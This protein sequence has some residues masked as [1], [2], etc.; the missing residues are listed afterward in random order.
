[1][2]FV[3]ETIIANHKDEI[4]QAAA[5]ELADSMR[6]SKPV[7]ERFCDILEEELK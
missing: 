4:I 5:R 2:D 1:M 3:K 7:R 6:R